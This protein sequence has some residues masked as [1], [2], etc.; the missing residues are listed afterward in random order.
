MTETLNQSKKGSKGF[1]GFGISRDVELDDELRPA[2][3]IVSTLAQSLLLEQ[4]SPNYETNQESTNNLQ[5]VPFKGSMQDS[6][7]KHK[8]A[9]LSPLTS[10]ENKMLGVTNNLVIYGEENNLFGGN[11]PSKEQMIKEGNWMLDK[12]MIATQKHMN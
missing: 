10:I 6:L 2:D 4:T 8:P 11:G 12:K 7:L 9:F 1:K 5:A 3:D